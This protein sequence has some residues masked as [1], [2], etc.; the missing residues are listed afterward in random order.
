MEHSCVD[1]FVVMAAR[2]ACCEVSGGTYRLFTCA[3]LI[4]SVAIETDGL[5]FVRFRGFRD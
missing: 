5:V 4:I 1:M 3:V 2:L